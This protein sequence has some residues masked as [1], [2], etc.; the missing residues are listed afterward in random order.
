M[1]LEQL[2]K[3]VLPAANYATQHRFSD[4]TAVDA[5][6]RTPDGLVPIDSKFPI[7]SYRRLLDA[8]TEEERTKLRRAFMRDVRVCVEGTAKYI[9]PGEG[10]MDFAFMYVPS[11]GIFY[12]VIAGASEEDALLFAN[13]RQVQ[14]VSP[15]TFYAFLQVVARGLQRM[16]VQEDVKEFMARLAQVK[17][18]FGRFRVEFDKLGGHLGHAK[19]KYD[20]L[21]KFAV[22]IDSRLNAAV[23]ESYQ[24]PLPDPQAAP[25]PLLEASTT[26]GGHEPH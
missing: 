25:A 3:Q 8:A 12:E 20:E 18:E 7:D 4:G 6:I 24:A 14:L 23:D 17:R 19:N 1:L 26:N 5:V 2:L 21:D 10:T 15:N 13:E 16:Q 22:K 9:R 11:E